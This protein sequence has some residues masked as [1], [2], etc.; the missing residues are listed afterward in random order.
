MRSGTRILTLLNGATDHVLSEP[1]NYRLPSEP[2]EVHDIGIV[3]NSDD[4]ETVNAAVGLEP[5]AKPKAKPKTPPVKETP[6]AE[7]G[8]VTPPVETAGEETPPSRGHPPGRRATPPVE[9]AGEETPPVEEAPPVETARRPE[10]LRLTG[11]H[12]RQPRPAH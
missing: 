3:S 5:E 12:R 1:A 10:A 2:P 8:E 9:A 11:G 7:A 4:Q 6:P